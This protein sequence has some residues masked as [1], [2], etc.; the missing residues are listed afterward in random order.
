MLGT[1]FAMNVNEM[2]KSMSE[3][4]DLKCH[5]FWGLPWVNLG[6]HAVE[7]LSK[8]QRPK[9]SVFFVRIVTC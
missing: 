4:N 9:L 1:A 7:L 3:N 5:I 8:V 6:V 2:Y